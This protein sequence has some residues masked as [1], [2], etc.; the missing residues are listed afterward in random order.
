MIKCT[1]AIITYIDSNSF[2]YSLVW[3][4]KWRSM[5]SRQGSGEI[6]PLPFNMTFNME[7]SV[8]EG[9]KIQEGQS[10][11]HIKNKLTTQT[12]HKTQDRKL[13]TKQHEPH[14]KRDLFVRVQCLPDFNATTYLIVYAKKV[15]RKRWRFHFS[16]LLQEY[17][18][19]YSCSIT[20]QQ[21][22]ARS[23]LERRQARSDNQRH[24]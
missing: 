3:C 8:K 5:Y 20:P 6:I 11:S 13:K 7:T 1:H 21:Q 4:M 14:Q 12:E 16:K 17:Q 18:A 22:M 23:L 24:L 19:T 9:R 2:M 10:N 15:Y